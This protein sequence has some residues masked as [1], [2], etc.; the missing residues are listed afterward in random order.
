M[1]LFIDKKL[2]IP[3]KSLRTVGC[4]TS[5]LIR[6]F[7][8][9]NPLSSVSDEFVWETVR[10]DVDFSNKKKMRGKAVQAG[11]VLILIYPT[12]ISCNMFECR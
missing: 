5:D 6:I 4:Q 12:E 3:K 10:D 9:S 7:D 11:L 2:Q 1:T 8:L